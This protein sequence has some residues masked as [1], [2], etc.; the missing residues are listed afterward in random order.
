MIE[1]APSPASLSGSGTASGPIRSPTGAPST[2]SLQRR[3]WFA[4]TST[5]TIQ[6]SS[7]TR[8]AVPIP[9]LKPWQIIP[10]PPPT[11]PSST[12]P[13]CAASRASKTCSDRTW[14]PLMSLRNPSHVSPT[15]GRLQSLSPGR[16]AA[17]SASRTTP[18][19]CVFVSPIGVVSMPESR[20]HSSP[21]SSPLPLIVCEA[22]KSGVRGTTTVTP[23]RTSSPSI[24]VVC[25]TAMPATSVIAFSGPGG[26][27]PIS[28]PRSR[29]RGFTPRA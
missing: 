4:W 10:V 5:P 1:P 8:D 20:I 17:T 16:A 25:P 3:P 21:V 22:A 11:D 2:R 27:R 29:A 15:T 9:P 12:G 23:V 24:S 28:I 18:T 7:T 13:S 6:P 14:K 26:S 19:E